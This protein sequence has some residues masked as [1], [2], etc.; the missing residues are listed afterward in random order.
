MRVAYV[1]ENHWRVIA[2][3]NLS[4]TDFNTLV[5]DFK[6]G[7]PAPEAIRRILATRLVDQ[8]VVYGKDPRIIELIKHEHVVTWVDTMREIFRIMSEEF[9]AGKDYEIVDIGDICSD[10]VRALTR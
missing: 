9:D 1:I 10:Y 4:M 2:A 8:V 3:V 7:Q 6:P 5:G